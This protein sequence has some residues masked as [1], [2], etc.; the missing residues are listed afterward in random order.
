MVRY[1]LLSA[2]HDW[3]ELPSELCPLKQLSTPDVPA[4]GIRWLLG[5]FRY[6]REQSACS[7]ANARGYA[8]KLWTSSGCDAANQAALPHDDRF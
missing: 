6:Y 5:G 1:Q 8:S 4:C 3:R 2:V 7:P